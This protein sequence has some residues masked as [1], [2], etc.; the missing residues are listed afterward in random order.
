[1]ALLLVMVPELKSAVSDSVEE[2]GSNGVD[3]GGGVGIDV[4]CL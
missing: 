3:V 4:R 1:M 2:D